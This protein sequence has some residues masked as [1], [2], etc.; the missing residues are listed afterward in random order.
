MRSIRDTQCCLLDGRVT[1]EVATNE[2]SV[3]MPVVFGV[4]GGMNAGKAASGLDESLQVD[5]RGTMEN[6]PG[7]VQEDDS[8]ILPQ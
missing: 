6:V 7:R 4:G 8:S 2:S 3:P 5:F 1:R